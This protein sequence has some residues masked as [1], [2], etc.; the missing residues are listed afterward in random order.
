MGRG[1]VYRVGRPRQDR[2]TRY[3]IPRPDPADPDARSQPVGDMYTAI[4]IYILLSPTSRPISIS[5]TKLYLHCICRFL[6]PVGYIYIYMYVY[7][8]TAEAGAT[9][10]PAAAAAEKS[11][12]IRL[13]L[14]RQWGPG[15]GGG[16]GGWGWRR[17]MHP[18]HPRVG[19][20]DC[21]GASGPNRR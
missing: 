13:K 11:T 5:I 9:S 12:G 3:A 2:P 10:E 1:I 21:G 17:R 8:Y 14:K 7:I 4:Y 18:S 16:D 19:K 20:E 15:Q 6:Q